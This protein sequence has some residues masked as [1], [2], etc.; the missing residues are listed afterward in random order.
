MEILYSTWDPYTDVIIAR[1]DG[2]INFKDLIENETYSEEVVE[3]G[4]KM[5]LITESKDRNL[6]PNIQVLN[7]KGEVI[8][9]SS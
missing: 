7:K 8:S 5:L 1:S 2:V 6:S 4:K 9:G 3:G